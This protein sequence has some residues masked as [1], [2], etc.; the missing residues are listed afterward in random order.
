MKIRAAQF[1]KEK[2]TAEA[3]T[4]KT[5]IAKENALK[6]IEVRTELIAKSTEDEERFQRDAENLLKTSEASRQRSAELERRIKSMEART[7][8]L[9]QQI[10]TLTLE[11]LRNA[12]SV[13]Q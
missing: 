4:A 13:P 7:D 9:Y 6:Q 2:I 12:V 1:V 11:R 10:Q 3:T 5:Q 8:S